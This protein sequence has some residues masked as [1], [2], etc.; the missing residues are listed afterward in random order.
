MIS[1]GKFFIF[2]DKEDW[3]KRHN[4]TSNR[5]MGCVFK[6][7]IPTNFPI[8]YQKLDSWDVHFCDDDLVVVSVEIAKSE[9]EMT[10]LQKTIDKLNEI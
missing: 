3:E 10:I 1:K 9:I 6:G 5:L 8:A 7:G 4:K 2:T